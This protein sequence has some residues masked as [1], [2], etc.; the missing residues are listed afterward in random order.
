LPKS[1]ARKGDEIDQIERWL[2]DAQVAI[3]TDYR[4][5]SVAQITQL[6]GQLRPSGAEIHVVK[7]TL[8]R[9]AAER[10]GIEGLTPL[11]E[12]PTAIT[13]GSDDVAAPARALEDAARTLPMLQ[14]KGAVLGGRVMAAADVKRLAGL[15]PRPQLRAQLVGNI[16]GTLA[17]FVGVLN[18]AVASLVYT[19]EARS[20]QLESQPAS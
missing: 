5:L 4:G 14:V 3:L 19:L 18:G 1:R 17:G 20:S 12:G 2:R 11:L 6:R 9:L 15:A 10:V 8:T 13:F 7:N 16:Q